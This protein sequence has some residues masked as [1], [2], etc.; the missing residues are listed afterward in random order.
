MDPIERAKLLADDI[1]NSPEYL[2]YHRHKDILQD[3]DAIMALLKEYGKMQMNIQLQVA[4]GQNPDSDAVQR[5]N[6]LSALL[7]ADERT[8][9]YLLAQMKMQKLTADVLQIIG[10]A[11]DLNDQMSI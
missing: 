7:F 1:K 11:A 3:D 8:S 4:A 9:S 2:E 6:Q 5:F 10:A